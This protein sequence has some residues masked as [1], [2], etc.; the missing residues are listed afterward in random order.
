VLGINVGASTATFGSVARAN[1]SNGFKEGWGS[2]AT[3]TS[4]GL[5]MLVRQ[6]TRVSNT[7]TNI[8]YGLSYPARTIVPGEPEPFVPVQ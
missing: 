4:S 2:L 8:Y 7:Q 5:P 6:F 1:V 3:P